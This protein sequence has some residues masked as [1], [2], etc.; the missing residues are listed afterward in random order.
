MTLVKSTRIN[1][2][3]MLRRSNL[4]IGE[5]NL[6]R[7]KKQSEYPLNN[8]SMNSNQRRQFRLVPYSSNST[9]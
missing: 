3:I 2:D 9:V 1:P 5:S 8:L 7:K 6:N 4:L